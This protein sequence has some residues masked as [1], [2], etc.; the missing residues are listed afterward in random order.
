VTITAG[1]VGLATAI[2]L[3]GG[4]NA[5]HYPIRIGGKALF[6]WQAYVPIFF[7][8]FVL[9]AALATMASVIVFCKL[10]R[11]HSPLH[12]SGVMREVTSDRFALVLKT[13][14]EPG[15]E[16]KARMLLQSA[17]CRDIRPLVENEEED[18]AFL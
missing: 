13:W 11:W 6:S 10:G 18:E 4:L 14:G 5:L 1:F 7:E 2:A 17:E 9:F 15:M 16:E 12:D 8:L 3:T